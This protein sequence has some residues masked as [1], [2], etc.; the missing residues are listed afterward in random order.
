M[1][2]VIFE[3][4]CNKTILYKEQNELNFIPYLAYTLKLKNHK[5]RQ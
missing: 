2:V 5:N 1:S 4:I 3:I